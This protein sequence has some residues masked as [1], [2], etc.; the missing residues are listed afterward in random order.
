M[1]T[2]HAAGVIGINGTALLTFDENRASSASVARLL[3]GS[4]EVTRAMSIS[5]LVLLLDCSNKRASSASASQLL[6]GLRLRSP[7]FEHHWCSA[8]PVIQLTTCIISIS[9]VALYAGVARATHIMSIS[10]RAAKKSDWK[11]ASSAS[12]ALL[13]FEFGQRSRHHEHQWHDAVRRLRLDQDPIAIEMQLE[14]SII[15]I[16]CPAVAMKS[17]V[18]QTS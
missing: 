11:R 10:D 3:F 16:R 6:F 12:A 13:L 2:F 9:C 4:L 14:A 18:Q 5:G 17:F 15:S 1:E 7:H 8:I